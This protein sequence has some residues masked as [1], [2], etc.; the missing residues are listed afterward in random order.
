MLQRKLYLMQS[1]TKEELAQLNNSD[2][3]LR[4]DNILLEREVENYGAESVARNKV[5]RDMRSVVTIL[6]TSHVQ[7]KDDIKQ[8]KICYLTFNTLL[9]LEYTS[10]TSA[11]KNHYVYRHNSTMTQN[12]NSSS[13]QVTNGALTQFGIIS[14]RI[15]MECFMQ[16]LHYLDTDEEIKAKSTFK[17]FKKWL[18]NPSNPFSYFATHTLSAFEFDRK[19]RTPEVHASSKLS[20]KILLMGEPDNK[21]QNNMLELE[22]ILMNVWQSLI[23][24]LND[25]HCSSMMGQ[26]NFEWH[27]AYLH[28]T[29]AEKEDFLKSIFEK[30]K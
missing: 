24:I 19:Y 10:L 20:S 17:A 4:M 28:G 29:E 13:T 14:S 25:G 7:K 2:L 12:W 26:E 11:F 18:N 3:A 9:Q 6:N 23:E 30:M 16:L 8:R 5:F 1:V 21:E 15:T 22:G 27:K